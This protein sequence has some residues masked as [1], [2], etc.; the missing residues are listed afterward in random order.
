MT[1]PWFPVEPPAEIVGLEYLPG[2]AHE[3]DGEGS[4]FLLD[5]FAA[6]LGGLPVAWAMPVW[7]Y[8][9]KPMA[10]LTLI[11]GEPARL[12]GSG[13]G[14]FELSVQ[15]SFEALGPGGLV[16]GMRASSNESRAGAVKAGAP[17]LWPD[18]T[19]AGT[20]VDDLTRQDLTPGPEALT[21]MSV[22]VGRALKTE[23]YRNELASVCVETARIEAVTM[24]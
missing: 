5:S 17:L 8:A 24:N 16:G 4:L 6:S 9:D 1:G 14:G 15:G 21:C 10:T 2:Q 13:C 7:S 11:D 18:G 22:P 23:R 3:R 19:S 12:H 20:V